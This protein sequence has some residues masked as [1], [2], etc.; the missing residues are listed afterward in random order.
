M[1]KVARDWSGARIIESIVRSSTV[2]TMH[3]NTG[4]IGTAL[5]FY[6]FCTETALAVLP[7]R[8]LLQYGT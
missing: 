6:E 3:G 5:A 8:L 2:G 7:V 1:L 4:S